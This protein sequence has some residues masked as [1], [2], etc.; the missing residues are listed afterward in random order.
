MENKRKSFKLKINIKNL[1]K[2]IDVI[3]D[4]T[5]IKDE[6]VLKINSDT[7][8]IYC[9]D[10]QGD[11]INSIKS[12]IFK[13]TELFIN[14]EIIVPFVFFKKDGK[15]F[16]N[17]LDNYVSFEK[18]VNIEIFYDDINDINFCDV[19]TF[20]NSKLKLKFTSSSSYETNIKITSELLKS[21]FNV[22]LANFNFKLSK[23]DFEQIKK[24]L[25]LEDNDII[26]LQL[27]SGKLTLSQKDWDLDLL[28][29]IDYQNSNYVIPKKT[30][31]TIKIDDDFVDIYVFESYIYIKSDNCD[32]IIMLETI[33]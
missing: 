32:F 12:F 4:L 14:E 7:T 9:F 22:N 17:T 24:L 29:G 11:Q 33:L 21:K 25:N 2:F 27:L 5:K 28:E 16:A 10:G 18:D 13:T 15:K 30:F 26:E 8:L 31:K 23:V 19:M 3:K 6:F 1:E 20:N